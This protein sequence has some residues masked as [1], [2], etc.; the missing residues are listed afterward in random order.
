VYSRTI[1]APDE[2]N[3]KK[4]KFV[5]MVKTNEHQAGD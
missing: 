4:P 2:L 3:I 5:I 1:Y